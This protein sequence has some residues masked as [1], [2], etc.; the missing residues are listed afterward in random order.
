MN[1]LRDISPQSAVPNQPN[2]GSSSTQQ[3]NDTFVVPVDITNSITRRQETQN[4]LRQASVA[5]DAAYD[6][7]TQLRHSI[8]NLLNRMPPEFAEGRISTRD[9]TPES[10]IAPQH[11]ALVLT[12]SD[13]SESDLEFNRHIQRL[14]TVIPSSARQRLEDFENTARHRRASSSERTLHMSRNRSQR[15]D[16]DT[17]ADT[18]SRAL[19]PRAR[20]PPLPDLI[21]PANNNQWN[22]PS[23]GLEERSPFR[24][25]FEIISPDDPSTMIGRRVVAR[26][27]F[28]SS[29]RQNITAPPHEQHQDQTALIAR[30]LAGLASRLVM[31]GVRRVEAARQAE[32]G[33]PT[34][35]GGS[36]LQGQGTISAP[37]DTDMDW[38]AIIPQSYN[39]FLTLMSDSTAAPNSS[40]HSQSSSGMNR[41]TSEN[42]NRALQR[43]D[44]GQG[45]LSSPRR[46]SPHYLIARS[47]PRQATAN[48]A[49]NAS[50]SLSYT[51]GLGMWFLLLRLYFSEA[52]FS[53]RFDADGDE[54]ISDDEDEIERIRHSRLRT[55]YALPDATVSSTSPRTNEDYF[56]PFTSTTIIHSLDEEPETIR[57]RINTHQEPKDILSPSSHTYPQYIDPLPTPI[58]EML[59]HP[60][61]PP[62]VPQFIPVSKHASFAGR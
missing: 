25:E 18:P 26:T 45:A 27:A 53:V 10:S 24:R 43:D 50:T 1:P 29:E 46:Q 19:P 32:S 59:R 7:V 41:R 9:S 21:L 49:V 17:S 2:I 4:S 58:S 37:S 48:T 38:D 22:P 14:R 11:A 60:V 6:R 56:H 39:P 34:S 33:Q 15:W 55:M 54:I 61:V 13:A 30:D 8:N 51:R 12:G 20:S 23:S 3:L 52:P 42:S 40:T 35:I 31:R 62:Q 36:V 44:G 16:T 47:R 28:A 5:L 57:V